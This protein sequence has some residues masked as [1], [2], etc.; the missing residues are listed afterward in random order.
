MVRILTPIHVDDSVG[1]DVGANVGWK[2]NNV[3][4]LVNIELKSF[5]TITSTS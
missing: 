2:M 3:D 5:I 1:C 4:L